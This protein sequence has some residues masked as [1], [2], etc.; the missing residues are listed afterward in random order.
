MT[1]ILQGTGNPL[2]IDPNGPIRMIGERINPSGKKRLH[3][4][5]LEGAWEV[6]VEET[7]RQAKAG[8]HIIDV[9]V[10]GKGIDEVTALPA[11]VRVVVESTDLPL[12]IDTRNPAALAAALGVCPGRPLVN[13]ISAEKKALA[14]ILPIVADHGLPVVLLCMGPEG[15]PKTAKARLENARF[16]MEAAVKAGIDEQDIV[17]D[18]LVMTTGADDKAAW[19][20]L[21]AISLLRKTFPAN[22]ITGG[23]SNVSFGMPARPILNAHF[24]TTAAVLGMNMPITDPTVIQIGFATVVGNLF[25]GQDKNSQNFMRHY[26]SQRAGLV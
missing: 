10:G 3:Q 8:A 21:E 4:A 2:E 14:E 17:L 15:I 16:G 25:R 6:V 7:K 5:M 18:P 12:C 23:S 11:A 13:S 24:L 26:R 22:N 20:V 9:N 1:S 19:I